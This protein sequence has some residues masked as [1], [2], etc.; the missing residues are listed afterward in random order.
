MNFHLQHL[1]KCK[2]VGVTLNTLLGWQSPL[3]HRQMVTWSLFDEEEYNHPSRN[4][5]YLMS[6]HATLTRMFAKNP[7]QIKASDFKLLFSR[8][9]EGKPTEEEKK[10]YVEHS[11]AMW[12]AAVGGKSNLRIV[13]ETGKVIQEPTPRKRGIP[14]RPVKAP[15]PPPPLGKKTRRK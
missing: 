12:I 9:G 6:L 15:K 11:K 14:P 5:H 2:D 7:G 13:D 8:G 1:R 4:D 3:T 10:E